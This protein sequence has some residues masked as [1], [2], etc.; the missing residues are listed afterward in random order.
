MLKKYQLSGGKIIENAEQNS[1]VLVFINPDEG[2][3]KNLVDN[4]KIDEHTLQSSLDPDELSLLE[5]ESN[6]VAIIF[7]RPKSYSATDQLRFKSSTAGAFL[8]SD[9]VIIVLSEEINI[10]EEKIFA[11]VFSLTDIVLKLIYCSIFHFL[12]HLKTI[13]M[14]SDELEQ[15][16]N[17]SMENKYLINLFTLQKSLVYYLDAITS[18]GV[19]VEK[20][21]HNA[22]KFRLQQEQLELLDDIIIE[23]NQCYKQAEIYSNVLASL[24]DARASIVGNNLNILIKVLN[25]IT[26][27]IMVPTLVVSVFSMNVRLPLQHYIH[28][29]WIILALSTISMLG[30]LYIWKRKK[31]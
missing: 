24:M 29:F 19:L 21:K 14:I 8:F 20:L 16:I 31:L 9:R 27:S 23:N 26:I 12:R 4:Y 17:T 25:I 11:K 5:F 6:H 10:F 1:S 13:N 22:S 2:E 3:R 30:V 28:A 15:K 7:K 18:N